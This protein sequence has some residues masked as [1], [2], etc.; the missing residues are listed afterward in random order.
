MATFG[1]SSVKGWFLGYLGPIHAIAC[2]QE[3]FEDGL[4]GA[5]DILYGSGQMLPGF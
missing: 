2:G 3:D 1:C 5:A 4:S